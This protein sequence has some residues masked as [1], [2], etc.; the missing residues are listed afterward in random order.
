MI[1]RSGFEKDFVVE[2]ISELEKFLERFGFWDRKGLHAS[3]VRIQLL[4]KMY[5][6]SVNG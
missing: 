2:K 4:S 5:K 6:R 3:R 1:E